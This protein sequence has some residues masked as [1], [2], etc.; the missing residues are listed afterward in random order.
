MNRYRLPIL[1]AL[2]LAALPLMANASGEQIFRFSHPDLRKCSSP[3]CGGDFVRQV[4]RPRT[5]CADGSW[6]SACYSAEL[7]LDALDATAEHEDAIRQG[8]RDR[9][10]LVE[11]LLRPGE[12]L[13]NQVPVLT[14]S[15][16]WEIASGENPEN[17]PYIQ[18][19]DS[20]IVCVT[21]PCESLRAQAANLRFKRRIAGLDL[22]NTGATPGQLDQAHELLWQEGLLTA[23]TRYAIEG[24][25]GR[26]IG[27]AAQAL[28]LP[29]PEREPDGAQCGGIA[30]LA[31]PKGQSCDIDI[32]NA[33]N[34]ADLSGT[35]ITP[36]EVCI[37]LYA[38]VCGCDGVTYSN[39]CHRQAA[40]VQL[41]YEG[42][43][44][45]GGV[46]W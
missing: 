21:T 33:C 12:I 46:I 7:N 14:V 40:G 44:A 9:Q 34:G 18:V 22:A 3:Q 13:G 37:E 25:G 24:P 26:S 6:E 36:P 1:L 41:D 5:H 27:V 31:C 43:C 17:L 29:V 10:V 8:F 15:A 16:A 4:N 45:T 32:P 11:G 2:T 35:C 38:P 42:E 28:Y 30:G 19:Q 23:G 39:N 20:G